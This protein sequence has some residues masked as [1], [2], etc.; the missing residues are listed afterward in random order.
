MSQKSEYSPLPHCCNSH[1]VVLTGTRLW[2]LGKKHRP[3][4]ASLY[5]PV[6]TV[7]NTDNDCVFFVII[8]KEQDNE[9]E[10]L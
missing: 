5:T 6:G 3:R 9:N 2:A 7:G 10:A 4:D 8:F 1:P